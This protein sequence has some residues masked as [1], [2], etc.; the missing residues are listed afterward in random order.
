MKIVLASRSPRRQELLRLI[1]PEFTVMP[2]EFEE[3]ALMQQKLPPSEM[4]K[5]LSRG[6][7]C[8]VFDALGQPT[9]TMVIGGDTVVI[10]PEGKVFGIPADR[11]DA[12][13]MLRA[14]SGRRHQVMTGVTLC[15]SGKTESF[16][17]ATD[18]IF[19]PL[20]EA[21]ITWYLDTGEPFDKA[22]G[23]GIQG[24]GSLLIEAIHGDYPNVVGL[25]VAALA[26]KLSKF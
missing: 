13:Q 15:K 6:K 11:A 23:Y 2:S 12:A 1:F 24:Y 8:S 14:L 4:V 10:S 26:R 25:P 3:A 7:A 18:V 22:G 16:S 20:T 19:F 5:Q 9:D 17:V 21:D